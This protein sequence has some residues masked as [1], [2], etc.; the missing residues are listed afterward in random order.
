MTTTTPAQATQA[1]AAERGRRTLW[2]GLA[3]DVAVAIAV[4]LLAW[5]PAADVTAAAA[6]LILA[7]SL[8]KSVLTA[9]AS[10]VMR[11]KVAPSQEAELIDG[12]YLITDL[13]TGKGHIAGE[14]PPAP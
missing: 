2:Q 3:L 8:V 14:A 12:A 4:T 13:D 7:A 9:L 5:L 6:W 11:L 1:A 10:Y